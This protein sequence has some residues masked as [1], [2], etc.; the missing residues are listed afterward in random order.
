VT[1]HIVIENQAGLEG[2][3]FLMR[4]WLKMWCSSL[5]AYV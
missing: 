2:S 3:A 1:Y 4:S 5:I